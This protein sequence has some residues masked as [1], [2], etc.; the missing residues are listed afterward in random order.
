MTNLLTNARDATA[1]RAVLTLGAARADTLTF[2]ARRIE[3][4]ERFAALFVRDRGTG[5][6]DH[7][8]DRIFEPLF[9]KKSGGTGLGLAVGY[10]IA[11][12][13]GG[14]ILVETAPGAGATFTFYVTLP[15][16]E[17]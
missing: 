6:P 10:Q 13:H 1:A 8:L 16:E 17:T 5:I 12:E 11:S 4:P 2:V 9:T 7:V 15:L 14:R 3:H